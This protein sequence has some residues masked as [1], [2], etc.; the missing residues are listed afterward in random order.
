MGKR[1]RE[2]KAADKLH[3]LKQLITVSKWSSILGNPEKCWG[4]CASESSH[5]EWEV[6]VF[7]QQLPLSWIE[8]FQRA[9]I[10]QSF[11]PA[12]M[13]GGLTCK[14]MVSAKEHQHCPLSHQRV[15]WKLG[16]RHV[17]PLPKVLYCKEIQNCW[18]G[19]QFLHTSYQLLSGLTLPPPFPGSLVSC[20][21]EPLS[22]CSLRRSW[23]LSNLHFFAFVLVSASNAFP[24]FSPFK[25][26][27]C[28]GTWA[29]EE[30][31]ESKLRSNVA[32]M[33]LFSGKCKM[34][35]YRE[36]NLKLGKPEGFWE[37]MMEH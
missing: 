35:G 23:I 27:K 5:Q 31:L 19:L 14:E 22:V 29:L 11:Q 15:F 36:G 17:S 33:A 21:I 16:Y 25:K 24:L 10:P 3:V 28:L 4:T 32:S 2:G 20:H 6:G 8:G 13:E 1:L 34:I 12:D 7:I 26:A 18:H 37:N 9:L 30:E